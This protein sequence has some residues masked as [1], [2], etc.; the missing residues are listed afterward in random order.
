MAASNVAFFSVSIAVL[1]SGQTVTIDTSTILRGQRIIGSAMYR[2]Q[3]LP[4][5]LETLVK[6]KGKVPYEKVV[7][8]YYPLADVTK[9]FKDAEWLDRQTAV[10]RSMLVP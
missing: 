3:L 10:S 9:A 1:L 5:M 2:P 7:S 6:Q 4:M 8:H